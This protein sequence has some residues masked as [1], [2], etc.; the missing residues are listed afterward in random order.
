M[1]DNYDSF[2][3]NLV[4][5][6]GELR[7]KVEVVRNDAITLEEIEKLNPN[8]III[9]PGPRTPTHAGISLDI[10]KHFYQR[11]P[12]LGV[13]L[14]HQTI[15]QAFGTQI[16]HAAN[17]MHGKTSLVYHNETLLF[18]NIPSPYKVARYHSL[19][20]HEESLADCFEVIAWTEDKNGARDEIM[21][22]AHKNFPVLGVQFHPE[23]V[24]TEFGHELLSNFLQL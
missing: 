23:S 14:G 19:V 15:A 10:V 5:Y 24:A 11:T 16:V 21:G 18:R 20:A 4:Q 12:I 8:K 22:I 13:C 9:S 2:T 6:I 7:H 3:Y 17:V 1:I